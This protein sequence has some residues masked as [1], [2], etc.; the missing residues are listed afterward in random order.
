MKQKK[1]AAM[2]IVS[3]LM[4][5]ISGMTAFGAVWRLGQEPNGDRWV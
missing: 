4:T 3:V 5:I 1:W 2:I